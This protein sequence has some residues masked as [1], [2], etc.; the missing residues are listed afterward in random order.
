MVTRMK[1]LSRP[2]RLNGLVDSKHLPHHLA[3]AKQADF[4][5][6]PPSTFLNDAKWVYANVGVKNIKP[7][8]A[9][10]PGAW[11][12]LLQAREDPKALRESLTIMG[13]NTGG[14]DDEAEIKRDLKRHERELTKMIERLK[15]AQAG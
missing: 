4:A 7:A 8:D 1:R 10:S 2:K 15:A 3:L 12:L 9:P 6:K 5:G 14:D 11:W 13:R